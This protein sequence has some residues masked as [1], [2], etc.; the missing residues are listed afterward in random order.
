V[1]GS[2]GKHRGDWGRPPSRVL[3]VVGY[4]LVDA[5]DGPLLAPSADL[6]TSAR[7]GLGDT[8]REKFSTWATAGGAARV[9]RIDGTPFGTT[10]SP[11][12]SCRRDAGKEKPRTRPDLESRPSGPGTV[13]FIPPVKRDRSIQQSGR[14]TF[15]RVR[16]EKLPGCSERVQDNAFFGGVLRDDNHPQG[17]DLF[18]VPDSLPFPMCRSPAVAAKGKRNWDGAAEIFVRGHPRTNQKVDNRHAESFF[19]P[20]GEPGSRR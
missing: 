18:P 17:G 19:H 15:A 6:Q 7:C 4:W 11:L 10:R 20:A 8:I 2:R 12:C 13:S 1:L 9:A 3:P 5:L 16:P 14:R